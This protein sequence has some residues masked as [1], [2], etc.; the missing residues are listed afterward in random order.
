VNKRGVHP[1]RPW[2]RQPLV[3]MLIA[4]P[5]AGVVMA[6]ITATMAYRGADQEITVTAAPLSKTSW[7]EHTAP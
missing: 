5:L 1:N 6:T 2:F 4:I 7:R 3:W